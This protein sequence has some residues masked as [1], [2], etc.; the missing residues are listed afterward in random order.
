MRD[1]ALVRVPFDDL[2]CP[3]WAR[4]MVEAHTLV[5]SGCAVVVVGAGLTGLAAAWFLARRVPDLVVLE[6]RFGQGTTARSGG[7]LIGGTASGPTAAFEGCELELRDWIVTHRLECELEWSGC[8]ELARDQSLPPT[9]IDWRD[10]GQVRLARVVPGGTVNPARLLQG[11]AG[12]VT[13][14]GVAIV[15]AATVCRIE[16][17]VRGPRLITRQG[18][19]ATRQTI[20]A[21]DATAWIAPGDPYP[22]RKITV[23]LETER[24]DPEEMRVIGLADRQPF[25]TRDLPLLWGRPTPDG[26]LIFGRKTIPF[27]RGMPALDL[28]TALAAAGEVLLRR[29]RALHPVL[30]EVR[31][32]RVWGGPIASPA[33]GGPSLVSD[34]AV[35]G[36]YWA[37]GY[38]GHG[39]AQAFRL[40]RIIADALGARSR[41]G[42]RDRARPRAV[43]SGGHA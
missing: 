7:I 21:V 37:G 2:G 4:P 8:M 9:P 43:A 22:N 12:L 35:E 31:A 33:H 32:Q 20:M 13:A 38:D 25:Y 5:P 14:A 42:V 1:P 36:L 17:G 39:L 23:A 11:L 34:A 24:L 26:T 15:N 10:A 41:R 28:K 29:V 3:P 30:R 40:G 19:V 27:A 18:P 16:R 6:H